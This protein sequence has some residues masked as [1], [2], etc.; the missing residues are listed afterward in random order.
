MNCK[1]WIFFLLLSKRIDASKLSILIRFRFFNFPSL[2][3]FRLNNRLLLIEFFF[4]NLFK[5]IIVVCEI[6]LLN[7]LAWGLLNDL[8]CFWV[9]SFMY[10]KFDFPFVFSSFILSKRFDIT[11]ITFLYALDISSSCPFSSSFSVSIFFILT[12]LNC[13]F[14]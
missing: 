11:F 3:D 14:L 13:L 6:A 7:F 9:D 1:W 2:K 5:G 12:V 4:L 10:F 8:L